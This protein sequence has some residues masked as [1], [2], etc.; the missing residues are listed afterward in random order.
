M[1]ETREGSSCQR[2]PLPQ[3]LGVPLPELKGFWALLFRGSFPQYRDTIPV[4]T[5]CG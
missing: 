4:A 3:V 2:V 1:A 5:G